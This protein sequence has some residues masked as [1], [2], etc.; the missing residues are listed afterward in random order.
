[1]RNDVQTVA[2]ETR[3]LRA[4]ELGNAAHVVIER[5]PRAAV[6]VD[7]VRDVDQYL[8]PRRLHPVSWP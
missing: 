1:M 8:G 6:V 3:S 7:P 2:I 4:T 5:E